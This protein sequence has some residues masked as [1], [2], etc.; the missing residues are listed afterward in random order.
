MLLVC[1]IDG[2]NAF[3]HGNC[4]TADLSIGTG[5]WCH[6]QQI[7]RHNRVGGDGNLQGLTGTGVGRTT[8]PHNP[9]AGI[10]L[11]FT[12]RCHVGWDN[13]TK[14]LCRSCGIANNGIGTRS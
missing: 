8:D 13:D 7:L 4:T 1:A 3:F 6:S 14:D 12:P 5:Y 11:K 10:H 9:T 2:S